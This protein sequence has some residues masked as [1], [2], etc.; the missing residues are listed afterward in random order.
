MKCDSASTYDNVL[1]NVRNPWKGAIVLVSLWTTLRYGPKLK[2][3]F[4]SWFLW[5]VYSVTRCIFCSSENKEGKN[6]VTTPYWLMGH[7]W[8]IGSHCRP[9]RP[10]S[11]HRYRK[12]TGRKNYV[13]IRQTQKSVS[14]T[15]FLILY[16]LI[17]ILILKQLTIS[18]YNLATIFTAHFNSF[19]TTLSLF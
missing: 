10:I 9:N 12:I 13:R 4:F 5:Y 17:N 1:Q 6:R 11:L 14:Q 15:L 19:S 16:N 2:S 18:Q 7:L 8:V 3:R